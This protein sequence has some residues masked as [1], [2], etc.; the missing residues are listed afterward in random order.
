MSTTT[1][2]TRSRNTMVRG[3]VEYH[4]DTLASAVWLPPSYVGSIETC[5]DNVNPRFRGR[6]SR[7][8]IIM[9][10]CS[11]TRTTRS[12]IPG[13]VHRSVDNY[14][15]TGDLSTLWGVYGIPNEPTTPVVESIEFLLTKAYANMNESNLLIGEMAHSL[16]QTVQM[17]R[18][19]FKGAVELL[20][21]MGKAKSRHLGKSAKSAARATANTWLEYRYGWQ[22]LLL[23]G[24]AIIEAA[25]QKRSVQSVRRVVRA[26]SQGDESSSHEWLPT[27]QGDGAYSS[28]GSRVVTKKVRHDV[29]V[30]YEVKLGSFSDQIAK[31]A[32][33]RACDLPATIWEVIP[34]SFV[35]D[36]FVNVG[37]WIRAITPT[38]GIT[39]IG[40]W[41]TSIYEY[42]DFRRAQCVW[43]FPI[44]FPSYLFEGDFGGV[45]EKTFSYNRVCNQPLPTYPVARYN[46]KSWRHQ[47]DALALTAG[48]I[49]S[50]LR[51][52]WRPRY[53][54]RSK[55]WGRRS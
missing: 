35:V 8:E 10:D 13:S 6:I 41:S 27:Y 49:I 4:S 43:D 36:W 48:S 9:S 47:A 14:T 29:G 34:Y 31:I 50:S 11:I 53:T 45:S 25:E 40:N 2:R 54:P 38:P 33:N 16:G 55:I 32:G 18:R 30:L 1:T 21:R 39:P 22:P 51:E 5:H 24:K 26:G 7:G 28:S 17:L 44:G 20:A 12:V 23:D 19:P 15:L 42:V 3:E 37:D 46:G 52:G